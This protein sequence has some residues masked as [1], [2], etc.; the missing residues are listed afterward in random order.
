MY[1]HYNPNPKG[2]R[3]GD[4][5]VRAV[6]KALSMLWEDAYVE[7]S[8][9][10]YLMGDLLSSNAVWGAYLKGK[11]FEREAVSNDC[12]NCYTLSDFCDEHRKG[13]YVIGTGAHAVCVIDG[14][15]YDAWDSSGEQPIY[16][17]RKGE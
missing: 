7:L 5:V 3:V 11:G 17:Y 15:I 12:P 13:T 9:Q 14:V 10:G 1:S 6:A 16:Y 2:N 4:C 8:I